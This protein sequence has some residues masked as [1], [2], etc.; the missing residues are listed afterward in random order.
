MRHI[1]SIHL[2]S[3]LK[4]RANVRHLNDGRRLPF[5]EPQLCGGFTGNRRTS[6]SHHLKDKFSKVNVQNG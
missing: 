3:E 4:F 1:Q 2:A 6:Q 5:P